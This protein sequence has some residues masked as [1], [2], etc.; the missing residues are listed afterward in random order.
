MQAENFCIE[1]FIQVSNFPFAWWNKTITI[2]N[3]VV[4]PTTQRVSWYRNTIENCFWK[5]VNNTYT[6]GR[7]G[8][9]SSG[10]QLTTKDVVCRIPKDDRFVDK[11]GWAELSESERAEHFTLNTGDLIVA[12]EVTDVIDEYT[13]GQRSTDLVTKYKKFDECLEIDTYVDNTGRGIG[14][15]HYRIVGK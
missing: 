12:G 15:E 5:Y 11:R 13:A 10:V 8:I 4:D 14:L 9:S 3:R 2:Y 7:S 6:I 1:G